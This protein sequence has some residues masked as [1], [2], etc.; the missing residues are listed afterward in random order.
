MGTIFLHY[1]LIW[2]PLGY[3]LIF[4]GML[5]EGEIL[6]FT[7]FFLARQGFLDL[8][9]IVITLFSG[10]LFGDLL[11]YWSGVYLNNSKSRIGRLAHKWSC[12]LTKP[13]EGHLVR[14]TFYTTF[15]SKFVYGVHHPIM[16]RIES[17]GIK[18]SDYVK[19]DAL[20]IAL[21]MTIIG[22]LGYFA[23]VY[24]HLIRQ[25]LRIAEIGLII[26]VVIFIIASHLVSNYL[27]KR[28]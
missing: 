24:F 15:L 22:S 19:I 20:A 16:L 10:S 14:R 18:I 26:G 27:K 5:F 21:W 17:L 23:G 7:S 11:W 4:I 28:L 2:K 12:H 1:F 25:Y 8:S 3:A 9:Y 6:I 13:F